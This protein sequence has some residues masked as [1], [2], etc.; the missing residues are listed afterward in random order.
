MDSQKPT[1]TLGDKGD[2][3]DYWE[4]RLGAD[5]NLAGVGYTELGEAFN[6]WIY[7]VRRHGMR[8]ILRTLELPRTHRSSTLGR[9]QAS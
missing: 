4:A 3:R 6:R 2:R 8:K 1:P 5:Y 7:R 9:G